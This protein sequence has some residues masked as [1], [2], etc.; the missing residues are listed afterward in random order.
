[1]ATAQKTT[2]DNELL[3]KLTAARE[4]LKAARQE[5]ENARQKIVRLKDQL[6]KEQAA[7]EDSQKRIGTLETEYDELLGQVPEKLQALL[8]L[9]ASA[10]P[11]RESTAKEATAKETKPS[12]QQKEEWL[13]ST[14]ADNGGQMQ[15][16]ELTDKYKE[17]GLGER[18]SWKKYEFIELDGNIVRLK[19]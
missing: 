16:N 1:M 5:H 19:T 14:L 9:P 6:E 11:A 3:D 17:A 2:V 18:V 4:E 12:K 13:K 15:K 10:P 7:I 8:S